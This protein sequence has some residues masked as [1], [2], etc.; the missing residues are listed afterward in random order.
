VTSYDYDAP[1]SEDGTKTDKFYA[2]QRLIRK[3]Y[4]D[5]L[6]D[7]AEKI[8]QKCHSPV[9]PLDANLY[10]PLTVILDKLAKPLG[11]IPSPVFVEDL[12]DFIDGKIV[13]YRFIY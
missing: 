10:L 12:C 13:D 9:G 6:F 4:P 2:I 5:Q 11:E 8:V 7:I 1:L 3:Y